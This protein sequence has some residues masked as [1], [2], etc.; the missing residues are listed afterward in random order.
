MTVYNLDG[1]KQIVGPTS[2]Q[3][4]LLVLETGN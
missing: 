3:D 2:T 4:S 1:S